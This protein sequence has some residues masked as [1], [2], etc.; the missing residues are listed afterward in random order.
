M[1]KDFDEIA[2]KQG[3]SALPEATQFPSYATDEFTHLILKRQLEKINQQEEASSIKPTSQVDL[4]NLLKV[5][6]QEY[7][8][9]LSGQIKLKH[10]VI[11]K[12]AEQ[13]TDQDTILQPMNDKDPLVSKSSED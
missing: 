10:I 6:A 13:K 2:H 4:E 3:D 1:M 9:I 7:E 11:E 12:K 8:L 5:L